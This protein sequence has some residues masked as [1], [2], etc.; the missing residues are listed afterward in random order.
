MYLSGRPWRHSD[1]QKEKM[2]ILIDLAELAGAA[3]D[4]TAVDATGNQTIRRIRKRELRSELGA[5]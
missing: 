1:I 4:A 2:P 3:R 5:A